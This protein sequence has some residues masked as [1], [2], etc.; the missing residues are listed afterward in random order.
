MSYPSPVSVEALP[1]EIRAWH[2]SVT[3]A[4][5]ALY[6]ATVAVSAAERELAHATA[7]AELEIRRRLNDKKEKATESSIASQVTLDPRVA[8]LSLD[9]EQAR[10]ALLRAKLEVEAVDATRRMLSWLVNLSLTP[11]IDPSV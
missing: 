4:L 2:Q 8:L 10:N 6:H 5:S 3:E 11:Q 7:E 1:A 9:A